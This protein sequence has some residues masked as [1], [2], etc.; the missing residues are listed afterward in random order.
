MSSQLKKMKWSAM[1]RH[2]RGAG[3]ASCWYPRARVKSVCSVRVIHTELSLKVSGQE[4][5]WPEESKFEFT[6]EAIG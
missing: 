4:E 2:C 6:P 5:C 1:F 3:T